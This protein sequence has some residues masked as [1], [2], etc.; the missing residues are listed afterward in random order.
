M[1]LEVIFNSQVSPLSMGGGDKISI[2]LARQWK[3]KGADICFI[4]CDEG[5]EMVRKSGLNFELKKV[6]FFNASKFGVILA[7]FFRILHA[8]LILFPFNKDSI[9]YSS[10]DFL[11]DVIPA[12]RAK[13]FNSNHKWI[14]GFYLR[15]KNPFVFETNWNIKTILYFLSQQLSI[16]LMKKTADLIFVLCDDDFK[17]LVKRGIENKKIVKIRG[18]IDL[19]EIGDIESKEKKIYD[20]C[21]VGRF[22]PQKGL[23]ELIKIWNKVVKRLPEAKLVIVGWGTS[24][25]ELFIKKESERLNIKKNVIFKGFLDGKEKFEIMKLSK[26]FLFPSN[27]ESWGLVVLESLACGLPVIAF[28]L[29]T[30]RQN[31]TKGILYVPLHD[32][33]LFAQQ[34]ITLLTNEDVRQKLSIEAYNEA[35]KFTWESIGEETFN[36]ITS[37]FCP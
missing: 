23:L 16:C 10:S 31:F 26:L 30:L 9:I 19:K 28:D 27:Y 37:L 18:G 17:Y 6:S 12:F 13:K 1:K 8:I 29:L 20:A 24:K 7:Y 34:V 25:W 14:A 36:K 2:M 4:G 15:A 11:P 33:S 3:F 35:R 32:L 22:H 5:I 21:F